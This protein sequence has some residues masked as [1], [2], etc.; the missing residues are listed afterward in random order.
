MPT[1]PANKSLRFHA[2]SKNT[3][4]RVCK[5]KTPTSPLGTRSNK[6]KTSTTI[7]KGG[8]QPI[9]SPS[10]TTNINNKNN[11]PTSKAANTNNKSNLHSQTQQVEITSLFST[12]TTTSA[13]LHQSNKKLD[14]TTHVEQST[15]EDV[16]NNTEDNAI[17][18]DNSA[19]TP[20]RS[21]TTGKS[22][23][24][25]NKNEETLK[26]DAESDVMESDGDNDGDFH[27]H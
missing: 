24:Q 19:T 1:P 7:K 18:G 13:G 23:D 2:T 21:K 9:Q 15:L 12:N 4:G 10:K 22:V 16:D 11:Q 6:A 14:Q 3:R 20:N 5:V 26:K 17:E 25:A 8:K 27:I